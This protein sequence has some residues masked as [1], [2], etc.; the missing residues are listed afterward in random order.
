MKLIKLTDFRRNY[1]CQ[2]AKPPHINTL[3]RWPGVIVVNKTYYIDIDE[4]MESVS[5]TTDLQSR[6][7]KLY[8]DP[9]VRKLA[10]S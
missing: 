3:K 2:S 5:G 7:D 1:F 4:F 10:L 6:L 9:M 8:E